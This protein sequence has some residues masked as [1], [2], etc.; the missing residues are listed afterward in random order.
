MVRFVG[1]R[2]LSRDSTALRVLLLGRGLLRVYNQQLAAWK[3][4]ASK[5][6]VRSTGHPLR[7]SASGMT[8]GVLL[9]HFGEHAS[10]ED[11]LDRVR[12]IERLGF[13][14]VWARDHL[15]WRPHSHE[16]HSDITFLEPF[17]TLASVLAATERLVV[18]TGI[19]LPV[20]NPIR[21]AQQYAT[22]SYLSGG[23]VIAGFGAGHGAE[24]IA[25][26]I[27]PAMSHQAVIE[28]MAIVARLWTEDHVTFDG[29]VFSV[30]DATLE[31]KP[32]IPLPIL[33]GGPSRRAARLVA[34]KAD[35][36]LAG[37]VPLT[38]V[39]ARLKY[40]NELLEGDIGRLV[41]CATPRT[42]IDPDR[43]LAR[44]WANVDR[45]SKDGKRYWVKPPSG[46]FST[47]EDIRGALFVGNEHDIVEGV[48]EYDRRGFDHFTFDVRNQ[49]GRFEEIL[50]LIAAEVLPAVRRSMVTESE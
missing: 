49:F 48:L 27:D 31:P 28:M 40:M 45:M 34:Q 50:E 37:T 32:V 15:L 13:D 20:R 6:S 42:M 17:T 3:E 21:V 4:G 19:M 2:G 16:E 7:R 9:P 8:F 30:D 43:D 18:G 14:A 22:M 33:Y 44:S 11:F 5:W 26:G 23:R 12:L 1:G 35:G 24:L 29:E 25:G 47:I 10:P 46:S 41:L 36:W 38:T 39:D